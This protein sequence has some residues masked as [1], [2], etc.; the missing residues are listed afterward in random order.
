MNTARLKAVEAKTRI[1]KAPILRCWLSDGSVKDMH[2]L[3]AFKYGRGLDEDFNLY[4]PFISK[5]ECIS[6]EEIAPKLVET[7]LQ[8]IDHNSKKAERGEIHHE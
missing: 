4:E 6:G 3:E 7:L 2:I 5:A 8:L 1:Q